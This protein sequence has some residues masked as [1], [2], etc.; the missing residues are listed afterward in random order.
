MDASTVTPVAPPCPC[1]CCCFLF[2]ADAALD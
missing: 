1:C 2:D